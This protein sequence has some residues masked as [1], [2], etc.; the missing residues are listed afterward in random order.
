M[1]DEIMVSVHC[2]TYNHGKYI[3]KT[4][5]SFVE[6]KTNFKFEVLI[7]DDASTDNTAQII[8]EF[9]LTYP[10]IIKPIYQKENQ[11]SKGTR[12]VREFQLSRAKGKYM[13][14]CEGDDF[15]I[16][17]NKLQKQVDY[18]ETHPD[19]TLTFHNAVIVDTNND[20]IRNSF[21]PKN[22]FY[23]SYFKDEARMYTTDEMIKLD[24]APT[25]SLMFRT[26]DVSKYCDFCEMRQRV[27]GD[28]IMRIL[29]T[30]FGYAYYFPEKMS[31]YRRGVEG[32]ASQ[33]ANENEEA[34]IRTLNGHIEILND[35]N[36]ITNYKYNN[37][38]DE[39]KSLKIFLHYYENGSSYICKDK[40]Y[41]EFWKRASI[42]TKI[43][44]YLRAHFLR[45]YRLLRV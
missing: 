11:Y 29:F 36:S 17:K 39:I 6:Q 8:H 7:H 42:K 4:L 1:K 27:C 28:L 44:F 31:A 15:W 13:A 43:G 40:K 25:N 20:V 38:I 24:F 19:C 33:R 41:I 10:E 30:S 5:S 18:M 35:F 21:L 22:E 23:K 45:L 2:L 37:S 26:K 14:V 9:E 3:R 34:K 16:D 32:S 12:I